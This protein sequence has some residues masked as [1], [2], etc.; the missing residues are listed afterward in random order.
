MALLLFS[1]DILAMGPADPLLWSA[2][3]DE[4]EWRDSDR[5][6]SWA[7]DGE[8]WV[9]HDIDRFWW[10]LEG[11]KFSGRAGETE[12]QALYS[13]AITPF[14]NLQAGWRH[15]FGSGEDRDWAVLGVE[16][17]A[18]WWLHVDAAVFIGESGLTA[19]QLELNYD[20]RLTQHLVLQPQGE[21]IA[22]GEDDPDHAIG[23]GFS[24]LELGLRLRY[25]IHRELAPYLGIEWHRLLGD[26]ADLADES[27]G[28]RSEWHALAGVRFWF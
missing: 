2:R 8:G 20:L 15:D 24:S 5:G 27:G 22:H 4:L 16:G 25:E 12:L 28:D 7:W 6:S 11:E 13:R 17:L 14:W 9:G 3:F 10:K 19:A 18:P 1:V 21:L 26:T 23:S